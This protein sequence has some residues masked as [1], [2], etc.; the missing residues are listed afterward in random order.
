MKKY[1]YNIKKLDCANC[2]NKIQNAISK[3]N[4]FKNVQVNFNTSKL[5]F[6][7]NL[8]NNKEEIKKIICKIE[9]EIEISEEAELQEKE[10]QFYIQ[11]ARLSVGIILGIISLVIKINPIINTI[12][13]ISAY[14]IL[15]FRTIKNAIKLFIKSKTINENALVTIS[16]IGAYLVGKQTEGLM[17]IALYEIGKIL[18]E[19]AINKSRKSI[20]S[21]MDIKPEYAN[22][23]VDGKIKIV[24]PEDVLVGDIIVIKP[25]EKVPMDGIV[26]S[27]F[28]SLNMSAITG[29]SLLKDVKSGDTVLSGSIN[30]NGKIEVKVTCEY[31]NSTVNKILHLVEDA[32]DKKAQT[33]TTVAKIAKIYTPVVLIL[34]AI[35]AIFMPLLIKGVTY[36]QSIYKALIFLVI[37]CPC[38]IAISVPLSYFSGIGRASKA[39]I[40]IKGSNYLDEL[41]NLKE[42]VFDKTGT[43]T[44]GEFVVAKIDSFNQEYS[45]D[46]ILDLIAKGEKF[47][48]HPIA[49]AILKNINYEIDTN[50]VVDYREIAGHGI[51]YKIDNDIYK[52]GNLSNDDKNAEGKTTI[53]LSK[54][55]TIIGNIILNDKIKPEAKETIQELNNLGIKTN[56]LT[57]DTKAVAE[58][59]AKILGIEEFKFQMLPNEK[60]NE[61][62]KLIEKYR[63]TNNKVAFVGDGINDSPVI[64]LSDIGFSMGGIG[65][66]ASIEASDVVIM[67]DNLK[68]IIESIKISKKTSKIIKENLIFAMA[69]KIIIL[70]LSIFGIAE[71]WQAVFADV[72]VTLITILNSLRILKK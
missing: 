67:T 44:T 12:L 24:K 9:S 39:G 42:I 60:Y 34:A 51:E 43:L 25:G 63:G 26:T 13:L 47:S 65:T 59:V 15:L 64:A 33:E 6:E 53:F 10:S 55:E 70:I 58:Q 57:G 19:K 71:M 37:S 29:E 1:R 48:N 69:T 4:R 8:E 50:K 52:V 23:F 49:K 2:A 41:K 18:E 32:T 46:K 72:G 38:S 28:T 14:A 66:D 21:L 62:G 20:K 36:S 17:V 68:K 35:V 61:I 45:S 11:I 54:N 40:L 27:G 3:D 16:C 56:M 30:T 22:L 31:S 7:S 5:T